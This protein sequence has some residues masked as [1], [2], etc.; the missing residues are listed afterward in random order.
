MPTPTDARGGDGDRQGPT[1]AAQVVDARAHA[2]APTS[3]ATISAIDGTTM[4]ASRNPVSSSWMTPFDGCV[5]R[6]CTSWAP[7]AG[8]E[9]GQPGVEVLAIGTRLVPHEHLGH[10]RRS[11]E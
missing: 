7:L 2:S 6:G 11:A 10:R 1:A 9:L 4:L 3:A 8:G 5:T